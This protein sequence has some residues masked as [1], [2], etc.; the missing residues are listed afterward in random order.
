MTT[1]NQAL[2]EW[3]YSVEKWNQFVE[4]EKGNKKEDSIYFGIGILILGT[5]GLM[6]LRGT[7]FW[8]GLLFASPLAF[9]IPFL[10]MKLAYTHLK[11]GIKNPTVKIYTNQVLVNGKRIE[12]TNSRKRVKS[13]KI[14]D[15]KDGMKLLE[16][17]IQWLTGK[18]PT[19]D[20]YRFLIPEG[21]L[22]NAEKLK[23]LLK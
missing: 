2:V 3:N 23:T 21:E 12:L 9:L 19:N 6:F 14:L 15:E 17:D 8:T 16:I 18:G 10:R 1:N 11:K 22:E 4:I 20:E 13:V 5:L 7:S